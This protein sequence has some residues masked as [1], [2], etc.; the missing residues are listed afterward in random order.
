MEKTNRGVSQNCGCELARPYVNDQVFTKMYSLS[1][2]LKK[3]TIFPE[4][5]LVDSD[6]YNAKLYASPKNRVRGKR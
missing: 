4:L 2:G 6:N 5:F 3:G 1:T